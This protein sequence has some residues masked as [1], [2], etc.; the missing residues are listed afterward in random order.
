MNNSSE[1]RDLKNR[2]SYLE[3]LLKA[4]NIP[5]DAPNIPNTQS[6][7]VP[8]PAAITPAHA[9]FFFSLFH[10][11]SDVYAKRAV[12]KNGKAGYFPVCENLWQ[13]GICPK[14]DRQKVRCV[15][16]PNRRWA[17]LNQ[18]VLMAHLT[19]EKPDGSDVVG[20]Y[21]LL[22]DDTCRFLVF[23]F[24]DH[25]ASTGTAWQEDVDA[26]RKIC[27]RN[28]V[29]CS[30]ERSRSGS[31][32]HV[33]LLFDAPISA[34]LARR[35]GSALLTKGAE[36]VNLKNFK[37]YDRML[38]AQEHLPD[39]GLGNLIAL[40]L[41][42]QALCQGNSAFVDENWNT[43]PNQWEY[44]KSVQRIGKDFI[45]EKTA[46]WG[47]DGELGTLS[48]AEDS[49]ESAKPWKKAP[50]LF[51]T[52]DT[53]QPLSLTLANGIYIDTTGVKP[54]LQNALR[55]LAAYSNPEFY[56]KKALG[57]STRNIPRIVFCG[58]DVGKYIHLPRGCAE[59]LTA[60]LDSAGIPYTISDERQ[61]GRKI[62]AAFKGTLYPQQAE[63]AAKMLAQ[64]TGVLCAATAF[65]KTAV[66]AYLVAQRKVNTLVLVHNAEIMKNWVEDFEKFLQI[67]EELPEYITPKGRHKRRK[68]VIGTLSGGR[69]TL[70]GILDIAM[71]TSLGQGDTVNELVKNYGM[72]IMDECHHAG[73]AIAE[74]VLNTVNAKYVYGLTATPKRDDGQEQ[75]IFMQFGPIRYRYTAKD[76]AAAQ[77]VRHFIY[78][79]FTRLFVPNPNKLSYNQA[80]R[81]VVESDVRNEQILADVTAC[82]QAGRTPLVLTKEKEHAAFLYERIKPKADHI[83]LLQGGSSAKQK[84]E[85]RT[86]MRAVPPTES[87]VLV[88]IGQY[89]GEGFNFP[90]LDTMMLTMPISWQGNVEQYAGRLHRDYEGKQDAIIYDYVDAH[91]RVLESMYYKRL[92]TY[93]RIG[94]EILAAPDEEKQTANAI[95]DSESYLPVYEK[96]LQQARKSVTIASPGLN[97]TKVRRL[98]TLL[99]ER[100][101]AGV[102]V[103]VLTLPAEKYPQARIEPTKALQA[104]LQSAGIYVVP[105]PDLH[106]HFAVI[107]QEIVWYGS[108]NLLSRDKEDDGLMRI[109]SRDVALELL[110][111]ISR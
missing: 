13:Y 34:E 102:N 98:I 7:V 25:E 39:G 43:Y 20:I 59:K 93:K 56:K 5:F 26:L 105:Q 38:P 76:R 50:T 67:D 48:K 57:F 47:A 15:S 40:P 61:G 91:I 97:K 14:A 12:M 70:G 4:H 85:L 42:G 41:Q 75:K 30:V 45:E 78:P 27:S 87:V 18:R 83:F 80:R 74:D 64:D 69:S 60:Q 103:T 2:I 11:R 51:H 46:V 32:A 99:E 84:E 82:L 66:G 3:G 108:T 37:T 62:N 109:G 68:S 36:S 33:W 104:M 22:L 95:F 65:G 35:F 96:D 58:E 44:L 107:D 94:Y 86:Q 72:V 101:T 19:G 106:T 24:D 9:R 54:R 6:D 23:D 63:A 88:A 55:R 8:A 92:R 90:R 10:G 29:P 81:A 73:A 110:G 52:E 28:A 31:G 17:P 79:R 21:P 16:C 100:Q 89:I 71:I 53:A 111:E 1:I 49:E 77:N